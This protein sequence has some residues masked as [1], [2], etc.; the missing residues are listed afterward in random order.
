MAQRRSEAVVR[1]RRG[2]RQIVP[3]DPMDAASQQ[4]CAFAVDS[5]TEAILFDAL[6]DDKGATV[7]RGDMAA[8]I[9]HLTGAPS[10]KVVIVDLD[11]SPFPAG[12]IHELA[13]VCEFGTR[14]IALG[15]NDTARLARELLAAG[16]N[17]YLPK[18]VSGREIRE[19][20]SLA[21]DVDGEA[22]HG[23]VHAG[24]VIAFRGCGGGC[25]ATTL[26]AVTVRVSAA[27]GS[28][29]A[30]LDLGRVFGA[31]PWMLDVEP[32]A[33]LAE[34]LD[35]AAGS[36]FSGMEML[37]S[38]SASAGPRIAVYGYR[39]NAGV[40]P[41]PSPEAVQWMTEHLANRS[42]FVVVDGMLDVDTLFTVL[43]SADERVLVYE[44]TL[45]SLS[46][47]THTLMLMGEGREFILVENHT[48]GRKSALSSSQIRDALAGREPDIVIPFEAKLP[49]AT[50]RGNPYDS[51]GKAYRAAL[52]KLI[53]RLTRRTISLADAYGT[54]AAPGPR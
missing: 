3:V 21:L 50:D 41:E 22:N 35:A 20:V 37:D 2:R 33:G 8:V 53:E 34:L 24:R 5:G 44:P 29:V 31:L 38:V 36:G 23:R 30:A 13:R 25:G 28:Y 10:P 40:P 1:F 39:A 54:L 12:R 11:G 7:H 14:V 42:H 15:S 48:R 51:L 32:T 47:L 26:A 27:R 6:G 17:D 45:V 43:G 16:V 52:D 9:K 18:P 4:I 19:A 49:A 46:R